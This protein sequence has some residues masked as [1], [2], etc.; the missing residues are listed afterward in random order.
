[1]LSKDQITDGLSTAI[2]G[3]KLF[4]FESID[5]TNSCARALGDAGSPEG[6]VVA[7]EFQT[8]GR[9][10]LGRAW[11]A[12]PG[13][14]LL[15]SV[16]LR[17]PITIEIAGLLTLYASAAIARAVEHS[18]G[19]NVECKWPNDLL[20]QGKKF[21]GILI[22]NSFQQSGLS[23]SV[24]GA[25]INVN[26]P[27]LPPDIADRATSLSREAGKTLDR[28]MI[29]QSVLTELDSMYASVRQGKFHAAVSEWTQRCSMFGRAI[30][31]QE[32]EGTVNG[33]ALRLHQ[34][35]GLVI[36]TDQGER[37]IYAGDVTV[38]G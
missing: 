13:T 29:F 21:C 23:Y 8:N 1:M 15:F 7:A 35:G 9:G 32:H 34:D 38:L 3:K 2:V 12:E 10:R 31:V 17:P 11:V 16:L 28:E 27:E 20:V 30:T 26:Q 5:S 19:L 4:L 37:T 24:I 6:A 25:G 36:T 33:V 14:S 22:E 18:V